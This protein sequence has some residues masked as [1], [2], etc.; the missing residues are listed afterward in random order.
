MYLS[1]QVLT[2]PCRLKLSDRQVYAPQDLGCYLTIIQSTILKAIT[3]INAGALL[4]DRG[5]ARLPG[6]LR[7]C[8]RAP[9]RA[10]LFSLGRP[11]ACYPNSEPSFTL[12]LNYLLPSI[13]NSE[14][15]SLPRNPLQP[16][17]TRFYPHSELS[18]TLNQNYL[19]SSIRN[20]KMACLRAAPF[21]GTLFTLGRRGAIYPNSEPTFTLNPNYVSP[22]I[23]NPKWACLR[24][25]PSGA[26]LFNLGRH[27]AFYPKSELLLTQ[28]PDYI[29][30]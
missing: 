16:G 13:R 7:A 1:T 4:V 5:P 27:G 6:V 18:L 29:S 28:H 26:A 19:L 3:R 30:P 22:S 10:T 24:A 14:R 12:N 9:S 21:R 25:A 17:E 8:L 20:P 15:A 11:G 23:R 2:R